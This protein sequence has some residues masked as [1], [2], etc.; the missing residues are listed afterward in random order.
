MCTD[1]GELIGGGEPGSG[2]SIGGCAEQS[3]RTNCGGVWWAP[4]S[5]SRCAVRAGASA[6]RLRV[7][8]AC[9]VSGGRWW[10]GKRALELLYYDHLFICL[11]STYKIDLL[12]R[13]FTCVRWFRFPTK[14]L[15]ATCE[16]EGDRKQEKCCWDKRSCH[17][18]KWVP[19][20][21]GL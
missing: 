21:I 18:F 8:C 11:A 13:P 15:N 16:D 6:V 7:Y 17:V 3:N 1:P 20:Q 12:S 2:N 5:R 10:G 19:T 9:A 14:Q 4:A